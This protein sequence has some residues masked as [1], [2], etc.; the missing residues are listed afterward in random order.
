MTDKQ[1]L[2]AVFAGWRQAQLSESNRTDSTYLSVGGVVFEFNPEGTL[3]Y[4]TAVAKAS[5]KRPEPQPD[6]VVRP[7]P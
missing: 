3:L 5:I 4:V 2:T 6:E 7:T 1:K